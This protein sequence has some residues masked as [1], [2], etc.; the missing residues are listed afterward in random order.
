MVQSNWNRAVPMSALFELTFVCNHACSFC[1]NCPTGQREMST[2][3]VVDALR[4]LA[5][6]NILYLTLTGGE[7]LVRKDFF[8]IARA[9]RELGS[10]SASTPT[11][12]GQRRRWRRASRKSPTRSRSRSASTEPGRR[13]TR[14]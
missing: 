9:A 6:F 8:E 2:A 11:A 7:P 4:K 3:E 5:D 10:R 13:R 1:Y 12:S 14:S